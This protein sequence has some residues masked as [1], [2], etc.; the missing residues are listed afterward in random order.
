MKK[1]NENLK[2]ELNSKDPYDYKANILEI[3]KN[4]FDNVL[5]KSILFKIIEYI[6]RINKLELL[7][8]DI[9]YVLSHHSDLRIKSFYSK[10]IR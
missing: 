2:A 9:D 1:L 5:D 4:I 3:G 6:S 7:C 8:L 10:E